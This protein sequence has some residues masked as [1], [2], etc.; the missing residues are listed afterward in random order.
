[1]SLVFGFYR[2]GGCQTPEAIAHRPS[3]IAHRHPHTLAARSPLADESRV[4]SSL[5]LAYRNPRL[6]QKCT[7][8]CR[9]R[10]ER[11]LPPSLPP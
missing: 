9:R 5:P 7:T 6:G 4:S 11:L 3:P 1:M 8:V 2:R 10:R